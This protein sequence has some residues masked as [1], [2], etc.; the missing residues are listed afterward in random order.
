M[1]GDAP[2]R[3]YRFVYVIHDSGNTISGIAHVQCSGAEE[4]WVDLGMSPRSVITLPA[5]YGLE[6]TIMYM[7]EVQYQRALG[8]LAK[9]D[10]S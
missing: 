1:N 5:K 9:H 2:S 8:L 7:I 3:M 6:H 4:N 10:R